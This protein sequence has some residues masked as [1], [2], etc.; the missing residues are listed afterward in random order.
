MTITIGDNT[1]EPVYN[2]GTLRRIKEATKQ[3]PFTLNIDYNN[4]G[5]IYRYV[6]VILTAGLQG[7]DKKINLQQVQEVID[8]WSLSEAMQVITDFNN[9]FVVEAK[10]GAEVSAQ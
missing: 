10:P 5:E 2:F 8:N 3:D 4:P 1:Y 9:A 6:H 7:I